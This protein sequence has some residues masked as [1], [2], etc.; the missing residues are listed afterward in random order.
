[1]YIFVS[2]DISVPVFPSLRSA[3]TSHPPEYYCLEKT[4]AAKTILAVDATDDLAGRE[5]SGD[6]LS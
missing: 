1:M 6:W 5:Q 4:G 2:Y 3:L